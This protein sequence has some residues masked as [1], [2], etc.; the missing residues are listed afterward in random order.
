MT[1][2]KLTLDT[3]N[4]TLVATFG[5]ELIA[6]V[7]DVYSYKALVPNPDY[8]AEEGEPTMVN[9][10]YVP[11]VGSELIVDPKWER[12]EDFDEIEGEYP[13]ITNPDYVPAV[14]EPR[15]PNPNYVAQ[16]G[17]ELINNPE[18]RV[19][20]VTRLVWSDG[21]IPF[22]LK[23][24]KKEVKAK[25]QEQSKVMEAEQIAGAEA[26]LTGALTIEIE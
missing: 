20:F 17:E 19:D 2:I 24:I 5:E 22:L 18:S 3:E 4:P 21:V 1:K 16:S 9:P 15:I 25:V 13:T 10:D 11:A 26:V 8:I 7:S 6:N 23:G 12:P 14:G